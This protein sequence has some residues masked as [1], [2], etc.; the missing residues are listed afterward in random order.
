VLHIRYDGTDTTIEVAY[1]GK[2]LGKASKDFEAAHMAQF[3][4]PTRRAG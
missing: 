2:D 4:L 3:G 1:D